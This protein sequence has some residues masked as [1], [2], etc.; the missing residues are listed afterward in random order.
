MNYSL[1]IVALILNASGNI[2]LKMGA[3]GMD[4]VLKDTG[5][6]E[7][8]ILL[9][10]NPYLLSGFLFFCLNLIFY[11]LALTK[12]K[13]SIAYPV[14]TA[15]GLLIISMMSIM[16]FKESLSFIQIFGLVLLAFGIVLV[17]S[18]LN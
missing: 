12:I 10:K 9:I 15:G 4:K 1:L 18:P 17:V 8:I 13:L 14:M 3:S 2:L 16:V 7:K 5:M 11:F 6:L